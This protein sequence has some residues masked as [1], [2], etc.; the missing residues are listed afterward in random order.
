MESRFFWR[1]G[2]PTSV[3]FTLQLR[4]H[5]VLDLHTWVIN[6]NW[7]QLWP[8]SPLQ[9]SFAYF[10]SSWWPFDNRG[11]TPHSYC[12]LTDHDVCCFVPDNAQTVG[13]FRMK[14]MTMIRM[15]MMKMMIKIKILQCEEQHIILGGNPSDTKSGKMWPERFRL[16]GRRQGGDG[17]V[18]LACEFFYIL[19]ILDLDH[20]STWFL[21]WSW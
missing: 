13:M 12:G 5:G 6:A 20:H 2:R 1:G 10:F 18:A 16:W 19:S 15:T 4:L 14:I 7:S 8:Q 3:T 17:R 21:V 9:L 11:G